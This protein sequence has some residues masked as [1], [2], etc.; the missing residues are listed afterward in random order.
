V[1]TY[2]EKPLRFPESIT[3]YFFPSRLQ[4]SVSQEIKSPGQQFAVRG[5]SL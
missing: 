1:G 3:F 5:F 4:A 2:K